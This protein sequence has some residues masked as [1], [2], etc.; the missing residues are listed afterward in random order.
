MTKEAQY[1]RGMCILAQKLKVELELSDLAEIFEVTERTVWSWIGH[2]AHNVQAGQRDVTLVIVQR[3]ERAMLKRAERIQRAMRS[4]S[5][6]EPDEG[7]LVKNL[8]A[9]F[10]ANGGHPPTDEETDVLVMGGEDGE[11]PED[12]QKR[13][14]SVHRY[15]ESLF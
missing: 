5:G 8:Q 1:L 2:V 7:E 11:V 6:F 13:F 15:L 12:L 9:D 4:D 3:R 10:E 14:P